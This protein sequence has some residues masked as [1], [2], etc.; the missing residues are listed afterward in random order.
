M[1][2]ARLGSV[3]E[4]VLGGLRDFN[5]NEEVRRVKVVLPR[6][7]NDTNKVPRRSDVVRDYPVYLAKLQRSRVPVVADADGK[8]DRFFLSSHGIT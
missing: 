5:G 6:F 4:C 1:L 7:V 2:S 8:P 3:S